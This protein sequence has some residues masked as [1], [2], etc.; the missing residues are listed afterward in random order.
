MQGKPLLRDAQSH[1][2]A[3]IYG[4]DRLH[5][6]YRMFSVTDE[7]LYIGKTINPPQRFTD[8][9]GTKSWWRD[10]AD[11]TLTHFS[12]HDE[13]I[14]AETYAITTEHPRYNIIHNRQKS[15]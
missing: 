3:L 15:R 14:A 6:L 9:R 2:N 11:I 10:I 4:P 12:S 5:V 13:L 7:L 8:H 1:N